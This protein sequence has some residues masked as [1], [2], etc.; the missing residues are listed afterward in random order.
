MRI[1]IGEKE[2]TNFGYTFKIKSVNVFSKGQE[3][4]VNSNFERAYEPC[5]HA[6]FWNICMK[7]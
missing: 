7:I 4:S 2:V 5:L 3:K 6:K 1:F